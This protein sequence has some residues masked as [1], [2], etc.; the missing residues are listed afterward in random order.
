VKTN[1]LYRAVITGLLLYASS[2]NFAYAVNA[3]D[4]TI[5][6]GCA[7]GTG[8][9]CHATAPWF[10]P[11]Q[12]LYVNAN[13][14]GDPDYIDA[15]PDDGEYVGG[16]YIELYRNSVKVNQIRVTQ[17]NTQNTHWVQIWIPVIN[18]YIP[19]GFGSPTDVQ[20]SYTFPTVT[21]GTYTF[22]SRFTGDQLTSPAYSG[23]LTFQVS[24]QP[25][26]PIGAPGGVLVYPPAGSGCP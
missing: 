11:G 14:V 20:F 1:G 5:V 26:H 22:N 19:Y 3:P 2:I 10:F 21:T 13:M 18:Q 12:T 15:Q 17:D 9:S 23:T 7:G 16:G 4:L 24:F 6:R 25:Y 8:H